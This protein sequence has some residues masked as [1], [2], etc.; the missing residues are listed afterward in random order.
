MSSQLAEL[1]FNRYRRR[2][3]GLLL[4]H[5]DKKYHVREIARLT[6]TVAGTLHKELS[7]LA[8]A[9]LLQ[10]EK[11]GNQVLY[12]ANGDCLIF[13]ELASILRKT[14]NANVADKKMDVLVE[15]N[16]KKI[17]GIAKENGITNVRV[18]GSM[19]R[20][21]AG[22]ESDLDLLVD[23]ENGKSGFAL[24]GF[25]FDVME[26]VHCKVDVVTEKSL[27]PGIREKVLNEARAL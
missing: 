4:L 22:L 24:G 16:R 12:G 6:D 27:H 20:N 18:F 23:I 5:P 11:V 2:V 10:K 13:E 9:G 1:L 25:L 8:N 3:L 21:E 19:A 26:L 7:R 17:L 14:S 15:K